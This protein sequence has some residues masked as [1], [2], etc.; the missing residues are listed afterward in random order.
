MIYIYVYKACCY[1][2]SE[3]ILILFSILTETNSLDLDMCNS[4]HLDNLDSI[5]D[6]KFQQ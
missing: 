3:P 6:L 4:L 5:L 1:F 2:I